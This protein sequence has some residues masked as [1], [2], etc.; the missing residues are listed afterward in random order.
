MRNLG[1]SIVASAFLAA[2]AAWASAGLDT[3][4]ALRAQCFDAALA[5]DA[6]LRACQA[7]VDLEA[8]L[9]RLEKSSKDVDDFLRK[10]STPPVKP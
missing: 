9:S 6:R 10:E 5:S 2:G 8:A 4:D 7:A 1:A 3:L